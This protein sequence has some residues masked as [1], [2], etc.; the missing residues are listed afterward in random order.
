MTP[1]TAKEEMPGSTVSGGPRRH[2]EAASNSAEHQPR[3]EFSSD[4]Q[5]SQV[6]PGIVHKPPATPRS[7]SHTLIFQAMPSSL[8]SSLV[9]PLVSPLDSSPRQ[10]FNLQ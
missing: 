9:S 5:R 4:A 10:C 2:A 1:K 7:T 8:V 6:D 3:I